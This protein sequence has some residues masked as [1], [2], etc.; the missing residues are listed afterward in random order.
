M[1][2]FEPRYSG[3]GLTQ[4]LSKNAGVAEGSLYFLYAVALNQGFYIKLLYR[5]Q[6]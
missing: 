3:M 2:Y 6:T 5:R 1:E 4:K